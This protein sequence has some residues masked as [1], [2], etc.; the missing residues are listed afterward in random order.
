[1]A[2]LKLYEYGIENTL[3]EIVKVLKQAIGRDKSKRVKD[4]AMCQVLG[5]AKALNMTV[6]PEDNV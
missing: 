6:I 4:V 3:D 1:M 5:M 2:N